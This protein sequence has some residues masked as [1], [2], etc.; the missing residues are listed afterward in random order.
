MVVIRMA[1][2]GAKKR[3][4]YYIVVADKRCAP[5]G[6]FIERIGYFNPM[7]ADHETSLRIDLQRVD[8]WIE[9]GACPSPRVKN[10]IKTVRN[11]E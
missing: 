7:A 5:S 2:G 9:R 8:H 10:L 4:Y 1:R 3:P 6:R 11:Q